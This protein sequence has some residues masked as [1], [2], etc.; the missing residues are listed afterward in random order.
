MTTRPVCCEIRIATCS[1]ESRP[2]FLKDLRET[3]QKFG[4]HIICFNADMMAG[5]SHVQCAV[6]NA[7]RSFGEGSPIANTLEMEALL[8][9]AGSRQCSV[10]TSFGIHEGKNNLYICCFPPCK[11]VWSALP[12]HAELPENDNTTIDPRKKAR[13][14]SLF[15]ITKREI[16]VAGE[17]QIVDL[18]IERVALLNTIR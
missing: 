10:A 15:G 2:A 16:D 7:V 17:D 9:A 12:F 11:E 4:T 1:V 3:A 14:M 6:F 8:F 5:I 13:L 18:V